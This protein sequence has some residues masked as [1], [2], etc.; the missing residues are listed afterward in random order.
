LIVRLLVFMPF[1]AFSS[2]SCSCLDIDVC[3]TSHTQACTGIEMY[4]RTIRSHTYMYS[5]TYIHAC[6]PIY[7][8]TY[9]LAH[10]GS[11][12]TKCFS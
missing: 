6:T 3:Y 1:A 8:Y 9:I 11:W 10:Q 2:Q 7:V 12:S 4:A 5:C